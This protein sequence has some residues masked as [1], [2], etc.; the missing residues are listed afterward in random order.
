MEKRITLTVNEVAEMIGVN[1]RTIYTMVKKNEIPS[2][3][4]R[5]RIVFHREVI[6]QWLR[7]GAKMQ[8]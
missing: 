4:I 2:I 7:N 6:D 3:L 5:G 1:P 8:A